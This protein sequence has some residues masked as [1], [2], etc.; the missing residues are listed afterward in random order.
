MKKLGLRWLQALEAMSDVML[1][2]LYFVL[3]SIPVVTIGASA[4]AMHYALRNVHDNNGSVTKDF[5]SSFKRNF[6]QAT[7]IWLILLVA[8]ALLLGN[9]WLL[10]DW[11]S[12]LTPVIKIAMTVMSVLILT[13]AAMVFPMLARFENSIDA[14]MRN[15][16]I[17]AMLHPFRTAGMIALTALPVAVSVLMPELFGVVVAVWTLGLCGG[18]AYLV[19]LLVIPMYDKNENAADSQKGM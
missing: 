4:T 16:L 3:C 6:R 1:T 15:S 18:S 19:Q 12:T 10:Q 8:G 5:F 7:V 11:Q 2:S 13:E 9:F 14:L 17:L